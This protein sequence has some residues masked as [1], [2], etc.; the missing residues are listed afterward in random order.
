MAPQQ[1]LLDGSSLNERHSRSQRT[2]KKR[3]ESI[4][5]TNYIFIK[6]LKVYACKLTIDH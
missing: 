6:L 4:K 1:P 5:K 2:K 3:R